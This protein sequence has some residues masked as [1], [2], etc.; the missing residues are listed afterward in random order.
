[1]F[2]FLSCLSTIS[3]TRNKGSL[4]YGCYLLT[5]SIFD[6]V[7]P[8]KTVPRIKKTFDKNFII[9]SLSR[10]YCGILSDRSSVED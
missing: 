2:I 4:L 7:N 1:M 3:I 8:N 9:V 5:S 10:V 6:I